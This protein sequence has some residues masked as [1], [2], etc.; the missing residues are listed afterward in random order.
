MPVQPVWDPMYPVE[1]RPTYENQG[2]RPL[3]KDIEATNALYIN[4]LF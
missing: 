4:P 2:V 1:K 3:K